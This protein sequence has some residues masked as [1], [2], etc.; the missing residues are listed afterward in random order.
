MKKAVFVDKDGTLIH[1][2]P[3]NVNPDLIRL[4]PS[5]GNGL[6]RL[7]RVGY[8]IVV[9]TNQSGVAHGY[10]PFEALAPVHR[11]LAE[12]LA[13][14]GVRL[15]DFFVC[16]HHPNGRIE[17]F[18]NACNCRKPMPGM[19][20]TAAKMHDIDLQS[21]WM[22]GDILN[23]VEAGNRAGC[24]TILINNGNETEWILSSERQP[25]AIAADFEEAATCIINNQRHA[26]QNF[27]ISSAH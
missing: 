3:Y 23:D 4:L 14:K 21:S 1:D 16:P 17:P 8:M 25:T 19:L 12:L 9:V 24:R 18:I 20:Q 27:Y 10:F 6:R 22:V 2:I 7:Q 26:L 11:R 5:V 13:D 15:D